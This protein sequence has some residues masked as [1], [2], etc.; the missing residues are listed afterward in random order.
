MSDK[1]LVDLNLLRVLH[2]QYERVYQERIN[3]QDLNRE[4]YTA[5]HLAGE[6]LKSYLWNGRAGLIA[7]IT[8]L[9][10]EKAAAYD[11]GLEDAIASIDDSDD[12][13]MGEFHIERI[14]ALMK[15]ERSHDQGSDDGAG[16][17][18]PSVQAY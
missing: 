10:A 1:T 2:E 18:I 17:P 11:K 5:L 9:E 8:R 4:N 14:R 16:N 12:R 6:A 15:K 7:T 13:L 3:P